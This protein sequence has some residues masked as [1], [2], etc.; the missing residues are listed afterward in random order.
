MTRLLFIFWLFLSQGL[1]AQSSF[2]LK[3]N[4]VDDSTGLPLEGAFVVC[5]NTTIGTSS[6]SDG[7]F[8]VSLP[9]GGHTVMVGLTGYENMN[10]RITAIPGQSEQL[11][12]RLKKKAKQLEEVVVQASNEVANGW[13][14]YGAHFLDYF[15]GK[16]PNAK[17]CTIENKSALRFYFSKKKNRLKVKADS[18]LVIRNDALGYKINYLLDSFIYE[19]KTNFRLHSGVVLFSELD[20]TAEQKAIWKKNRYDAY[21]GSRLHFMRS[22]YNANLE[23][24]GF[25][26]EEVKQD[27]GQYRF[28]MLKNPY[29]SAIYEVVDSLEREVSLIG[30]YR[31]HYKNAPMHQNYLTANQYPLDAKGQLS[32]LEC[33]G[34]F[35]IL[36]NGFYYDQ[37]EVVI[38]GYFA[39]MQVADQLPYDYW[40]DEETQ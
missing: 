18:V 4:V 27:K 15:L 11:S 36:S 7:T 25:M 16:T 5:M 17:L 37:E 26:L 22:Y 35:A 20:S 32:T 38:S 19:Y 34:G 12:V 39:W 28:E 9:A 21:V 6:I 14:K 13:E 24:D 31:V 3:G 40:P 8:S 33:D 1:F 10:Q 29:D 30:K 23:Q 2:L